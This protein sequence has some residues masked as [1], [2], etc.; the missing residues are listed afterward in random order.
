MIS[1]KKNYEVRGNCET[2]DLFPEI[3]NY[4]YTMKGLNHNTIAILNLLRFFTY[5]G[6]KSTYITQIQLSLLSRLSLPTV[7]A[8]VKKLREEGFISQRTLRRGMVETFLS[9]GKVFA[10]QKELREA[11][12]EYDKIIN[13]QYLEIDRKLTPFKDKVLQRYMDKTSFV[14]GEAINTEIAENK[15]VE[16]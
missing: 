11:H 14:R 15:F 3:L 7:G 4:Y 10:T 2:T 5:Q 16:V 8:A 13:K 1:N 12:K 9:K 6:E